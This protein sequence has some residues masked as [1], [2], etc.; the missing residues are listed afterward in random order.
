MLTWNVAIAIEQHAGKKDSGKDAKSQQISHVPDVFLGT[1]RRQPK[2][3]Q[4][5]MLQR[6]CYCFCCCAGCVSVVAYEL[7]LDAFPRD[8]PGP[9][10]S[11]ASSV[12]SQK[13]ARFCV[14]KTVFPYWAQSIRFSHLRFAA[15]HVLLSTY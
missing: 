3:L 13:P 5:P 9:E 6:F 14:R 12:A 1:L 15:V 2:R 4:S 8:S 11:M 7:S 10:T